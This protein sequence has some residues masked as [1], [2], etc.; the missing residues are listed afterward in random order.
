MIRLFPQHTPMH[1]ALRVTDSGHR[2]FGVAKLVN[3]TDRYWNVAVDVADDSVDDV[4]AVLNELARIELDTVKGY[5]APTNY[6]EEV[7]KTDILTTP[8]WA[9]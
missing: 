7:A 3:V 5:N 9:P 8:R 4:Q 2:H 6:E 1:F